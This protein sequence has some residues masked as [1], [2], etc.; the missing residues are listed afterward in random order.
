MRAA[1]YHGRGDIRISEVPIPTPGRDQLLLRILA[2][3]VCGTDAHEFASGPHMFPIAGPHPISGHTGPLIP[4][5]EFAGEVVAKGSA[6]SG[7]EAGA[8]V[9][10][11]A[12]ISCGGCHWC[13]RGATNLCPRYVTAG[14]QLAG[15]LAQFAVI[16]ASI[17]V[18]VA[19]FGL[20]PD[21]AA[22]AQPMSIAAHATR[23]ARL[24]AGEGVV[25]LGAGGIGAF[26][27]FAASR[28]GAEVIVGDLDERR[29]ET[30]VDLGATGTVGPGSGRDL[31]ETLAERGMVPTVIFEATGTSPG[32]RLALDTAQPGTRVVLVGIQGGATELALRRVTLDE[33]EL[34]G[35]N[36][37]AFALD[38]P[39]ALR[40]LASRAEGW[41]DI[42]PIAIPLDDLVEGGLLPLVEGRSERIKTLIDPW[43]DRVR[44][45]R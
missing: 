44:S 34:I 33:I 37:H 5:H 1:V 39:E 27:T 31:G 13:R 2:A 19:P 20:T 16:P 45:S 43:A 21:V 36:A 11:G 25:I 14:L 7:F 38:F 26:L 42:A 15:G 17:C 30:A 23:R 4:G 40:L 22:L 8:V 29:L 28:L 6:V 24:A 10:S 12:G 32:L 18:D 35:T 41:R 3:G 9:T